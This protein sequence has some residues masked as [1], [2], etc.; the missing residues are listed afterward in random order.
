MALNSEQTAGLQAI[1]AELQKRQTLGAGATETTAQAQARVSGTTT[2]T[3]STTGIT[4]PTSTGGAYVD[5]KTGNTYPSYNW[6]IA[7]AN[8]L[9]EVKAAYPELATNTAGT[10]TVS[11]PNEGDTR[12]NPTTGK[13][14]FY[15][16]LG[17][18]QEV[19][20]P[21]QA[22]G[23]EGQTVEQAK[24]MLSGLGYDT[25]GATSGTSQTTESIRSTQD[26]TKQEKEIAKLKKSADSEQELKDLQVQKQIAD[27]K[28]QLGITITPTAPETV[29]FTSVYEA[30]RNEQGMSGLESNLNSLNSQITGL[31]DSLTAGL[32]DE[33]GKLRPMEL[34]S[35]RQQETTR[36]AQEKINTLQRSKQILVDEINTKNT[37]ISNIMSLKQTDYAN[38]KEDY[39]FEY[40]KQLKLIEL[41]K[42]I[43]EEAESDAEAEKSSA[44]ANLNTI[45]NM[46]EN[47]TFGELD[48]TTQSKIYEL[49]LKSG[50]PTGITQSFM[51]ATNGAKIETT[52]TG[53]DEN[54][55]QTISFVYKDDSG[56]PSMVTALTGNVATK[57]IEEGENITDIKSI[58]ESLYDDDDWTKLAQ[59]SGLTTGT[60]ILGGA[61][62]GNEYDTAFAKQK[63]IDTFNALVNSGAYTGK[64]ALKIITESINNQVRKAEK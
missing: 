33:E 22:A 19:T 48:A 8:N 29:N 39:E 45:I 17:Q 46:A 42:D 53:Y 15:S 64:E 35:Q 9:P 20:A 28:T 25:T 47:R 38:A 23:T 18:W 14:E 31:Q 32:Y 12:V 26:V 60:G 3:T 51:N 4:T 44:Q 57:T 52:V 63:F 59:K 1:L 2:G 27:L 34:I 30:L 10:S 41:T 49:E 21:G 11:Q 43:E 56:K 5:P 61:G 55:N 54:G 13:T 7:N 37:L 58:L 40:N 50:L 16:P 24:Q 62:P 36:Q 6:M